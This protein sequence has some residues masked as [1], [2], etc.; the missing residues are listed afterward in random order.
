[1]AAAT[2]AVLGEG[3]GLV[4]HPHR[5]ERRTRDDLHAP[6]AHVLQERIIEVRGRLRRELLA[7]EPELIEDIPES[8]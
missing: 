6:A 3:R 2:A 7:H 1:M 5:E 4:D 8:L